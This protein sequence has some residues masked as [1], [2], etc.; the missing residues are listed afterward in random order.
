M[1]IF[2]YCN[3]F[4]KWLLF[5]LFLSSVI[6]V[7]SKDGST[8]I[9]GAERWANFHIYSLG[10]HSEEIMAV[11]FETKSLDVV[12]LSKNGRLV[13]WD[14][15]I[16]PSD[17]VPFDPEAPRKKAKKRDTHILEE[18]DIDLSKGEEREK[19]LQEEAGT[20]IFITGV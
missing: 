6:A 17:L 18:D 3:L 2:S 1:M 4:L 10:G 16:D 9:F 5:L 8:K 13:L 15:N 11:F 20:C 14:C 7:A 12:S 19:A